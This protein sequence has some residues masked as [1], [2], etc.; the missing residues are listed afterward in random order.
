[1][2]K[3]KKRVMNKFQKS[4]LSGIPKKLPPK[5]KYDANINHEDVF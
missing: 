1:M 3:K 2:T 4:I 5:R